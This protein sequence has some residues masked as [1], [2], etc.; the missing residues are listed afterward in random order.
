[1]KTKKS[2][3]RYLALHLPS[4]REALI[5][6]LS[7]S[8]S[9]GFCLEMP[10]LCVKD[11]ELERYEANMGSNNVG[12]VVN[13]V[14]LN[15]LG[16]FGTPQFVADKL[17]QAE[18]RK[19]STKDAEVIGVAERQGQ[20]GLQVYEFEYKVDSSRGGMKRIFRQLLWRRRALPS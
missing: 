18:K 2:Q 14:R 7:P 13:S 16:E 17:I 3:Q 1:M 19:E 12:V 10:K 20:G 6:Q 15:S 11:L 4:P 5:P 9:L 8:S